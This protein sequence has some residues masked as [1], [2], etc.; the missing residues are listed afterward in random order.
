MPI[1]QLTLPD[2]PAA[3]LAFIQES[4]RSKHVL[5]LKFSPIC[6]ISTD[7]ESRLLA[8]LEDYE[9]DNLAV[10][11]IDV[12]AER[13][14]ARGILALIEERHESP[15]ALIFK[16]E[17]LLDQASHGDITGEWIEEILSEA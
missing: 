6:P 13:S 7:V 5:L 8:W 10:A 17:E 15:Q 9:H 1:R 11:V 12:I 4:S 14:L 3:A 16:D 2:D